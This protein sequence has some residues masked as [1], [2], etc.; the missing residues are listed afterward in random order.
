VSKQT[1]TQATIR[2]LVAEDQG[3]GRAGVVMLLNAEPDI[4]VAGEAA[5]GRDAVALARSIRP[6]VV[7]MDLEMPEI[8]GVEATR[9]LANAGFRVLVLVATN[10]DPALLEALRAGALGIVLKHGVPQNLA[11][12]VRTVAVDQAWLDPELA[13]S[14]IDS[15]ATSPEPGLT[16]GLGDRLTAREIDILVMVARG[17]S[18][19]EIGQALSLTRATVTNQ[20]QRIMTK[21]GAHN[22]NQL[23][24]AALS[25][26]L[27]TT[28][29]EALVESAMTVTSR[30]S[31]DGILLTGGSP[32]QM[33][34]AEPP[35]YSKARSE[36]S[37]ALGHQVN[38]LRASVGELTGHISAFRSETPLQAVPLQPIMVT[39]KAVDSLR[40][41]SDLADAAHTMLSRFSRFLGSALEEQISVQTFLNELRTHR[42]ALDS[43]D[44]DAF[45]ANPRVHRA[46][47]HIADT[48]VSEQTAQRML[49]ALVLLG[50]EIGLE[51]GPAG[52]AQWGSWFQALWTRI[53]SDYT[54]QEVQRLNRQ[55]V[56]S[57]EDGLL[58]K[59]SAALVNEYSE[60]VVKLMEAASGCHNF[61]LTLGDVVLVKHTDHQGHV[62]VR[63]KTLTVDQ[64]RALERDD[65]KS[66]RDPESLLMSLNDADHTISIETDEEAQQSPVS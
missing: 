46:A 17:R 35:A 52:P 58:K 1:R 2:V 66:L 55:L 64:R 47:V 15:V 51:V 57:A 18:N 50:E 29:A 20:V 65:W 26:G 37:R 22:H 24:T 53:K 34:S 27:I 10:D 12:A 48:E 59:S 45:A 19:Q 32:G 21:I 42:W 54:P 40:A 4:H 23:I 60:A 25:D 61:A 41:N 56:Q 28:K 38:R 30:V 36:A 3:V 7:L 13:R 16:I 9:R 14:V 31:G 44:E 33:T 8:G 43:I 49:D 5:D 11:A 62:H 63:V 39:L 6:D